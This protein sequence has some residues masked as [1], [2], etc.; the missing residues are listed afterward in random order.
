M[1][2]VRL[3]PGLANE[4]YE[5]MSGYALAQ[6]LKQELVLD[7]ASCVNNSFGY[8]LDYFNIPDSRKLIYSQVSV[9]AEI[10][11][12]CDSGIEFFDDTVVLVE[13]KEQKEMYPD[14][15]R[16]LIYTGWEMI[17]EL[18]TYKNIYMCGCFFAKKY[19]EKYWTRLKSFFILKKETEDIDNFRKLI[20]GK[21]SIGIHIR[22]GDMLLMD[23]AYKVE[24]EYYRAAVQFCK[25]T[26]DNYIFCVFSDDIEYAKI[27]LGQSD[28]IHY[29][30]FDGYDDAS[31]NEFYCLSL[32]DYR[33]ISTYWS[34]FGK[35]ADE[36]GIKDN[37]HVLVRDI[38]GASKGR[39]LESR[40]AGREIFLN[41][42]D[43]QEYNSRYNIREYISGADDLHKYR[44]FQ[45][46][47]E[48]NRNHEAL[49]LAFCI[50][51]EQRKNRDFKLYLA[52]AL[53]KIGAYEE[54]V[55]ELAQIEPDI[56]EDYLKNLILDKG[57]KRRLLELYETI[58]GI[59]R[60]H[61]IVVLYERAMPANWTYGLI[62]LAIVLSHL[63]HLVTLIYEPYL[64]TGRYYLDTSRYLHNDR[65]INLGCYHVE[66]KRILQM[67]VANYYNSLEEDELI[68]VSRDKRFF[69]R[70]NCNKRL[71][72][73]TTDGSDRKDEE[74]FPICPEDHFFEMLGNKADYIL[75]K[76]NGLSQKDERYIYWQDDG[77]QEMFTFIDFPW[78]YG[79]GQRLNSRMINMTAALLS[80][81]RK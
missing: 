25:E 35:L 40:K 2:I 67:G 27:I 36:L 51:S 66:K 59:E 32:C 11:E 14:N 20:C 19:Y 21:L 76:D 3:S 63:G 81:Y 31:V 10:L 61:F 79:Y 52:D 64:D 53:T 45:K 15:D 30:H 4:I 24:D 26:Y 1:L 74:V 73:I 22:R 70:E 57:K 72:F 12:S 47:V 42:E 65:G 29:V 41:E 56:A 78:K 28:S 6:E 9:G 60:K 54:S 7:I 8:L 48:Q 37:G 16:V 39:S 43:I 80:I 23:W 5:Y 68:I 46:L 55:V 49:Q 13:A 62:D 58:R 75:T 38:Y 17:D 44:K 71:Q 18:K 33:I 69:T 77:V 50:Y 34:T